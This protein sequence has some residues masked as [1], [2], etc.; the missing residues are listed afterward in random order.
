MKKFIEPKFETITFDVC[1]VLTVLN[2][3]TGI[4][5]YGL[6]KSMQG[7]NFFFAD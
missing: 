4:V 1:D 3:S 7:D 2:A 5:S 6:G